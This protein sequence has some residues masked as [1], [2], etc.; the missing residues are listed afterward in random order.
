MQEPTQLR[1]NDERVPLLDPESRLASSEEI[2]L[3]FRHAGSSPSPSRSSGESLDSRLSLQGEA[4]VAAGRVRFNALRNSLRLTNATRPAFFASSILFPQVVTAGFLLYKY[5]DTEDCTTP[6]FPLSLRF[7][8]LGDALIK[9]VQLVLMWIPLFLLMIRSSRNI[10]SRGIR[11]KQIASF[12]VDV[13]SVVWVVQGTNYFLGENDPCNAPHL[14]Q[15]GQIMYMLSMFFMTLPVLVCLSFV[16]IVCCCFPCFVRF[17]LA[18][19]ANDTPM[20]GATQ[21]ELDSL[22]NKEFEPDMFQ[23]YDEENKLP[24][25][26]ICLSS[27]VPG[28]YVRE[29]PCDSRHHFHMSCVDDWLRLNPTCPVCRSRVFPRSDEVSANEGGEPDEFDV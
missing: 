19:R 9:A 22:P 20:V 10:V 3:P 28:E 18:M 15:L 17:L 26:T 11:F 4:G 27:Y 12:S 7:W 13:L 8:I 29:L 16:P 6:D 2:L 14:F 5:W 21:Q 24:Q 23:S 25:C 1:G